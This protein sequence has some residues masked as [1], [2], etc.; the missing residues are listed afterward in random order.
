MRKFRFAGILIAFL[1]V[2]ATIFLFE[3]EKKPLFF[4]LEKPKGELF[5]QTTSVYPTKLSI[6]AENIS[7]ITRIEFTPDGNYML[8]GTLPGTIWVFHKTKEGFLR[9]TD[10][11]YILNTNFKGWPPQEAGLTG[12]T[13]GADFEKSGD[14][15]LSYSYK[16]GEKNFK[17]RISRI[18]FSKEGNKV[19]GKQEKLIFEANTPGSLSHQIQ[20]GVGLMIGGKPHVLFTIGEGF[21]AKRAL[22]PTLEAGKLMLIQRDGSNPLGKRPFQSSLKIQALGLRNSP[23]IAKD[24]ENGYIAIGDTGPDNYDRFLY[25]K[26]FD[27]TNNTQKLS[28]NW[29]G[30]ESSLLK[31][32][33]DL[34]NSSQNMNL[35]QWAPTETPVNIVFYENK[36]LPPLGNNQS[37]V[38]VSLFGKTGQTV[39]KPGKRIVLGVI[40]KGLQNRV[41]FATLIERAASGEGRLGHP[42]GLAVDPRD[43]T[44]YFGDILEKRIYKLEFE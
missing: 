36:K 19:V 12:I 14:I 40:T 39:N 18:T 7:Q 6:F 37:Y 8:V 15:F 34:Y 38:L 1:I 28:F 22:D 11:F 26:M 31:F 10:P 5:Y 2:I 4:P 44:I 30:Q 20:G 17:N 43:K 3:K 16:A 42:I 25:G 32:V 24:P 13:L 27:P 21:I 33:P 35:F 41:S 29:D 23:A 9:Q